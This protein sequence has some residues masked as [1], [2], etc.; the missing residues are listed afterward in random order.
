MVQ[1]LLQMRLPAWRTT[2]CHAAWHKNYAAL[3]NG[4]GDFEAR[5]LAL[6]AQALTGAKRN[7]LNTN[8]FANIH[9]WLFL[10]LRCLLLAVTGHD[11]HPNPDERQPPRSGPVLAEAQQRDKRASQTP[12]QN[13]ING[14]RG[15]HWVPTTPSAPLGTWTDGELG[16]PADGP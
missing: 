5:W 12:V 7:T 9:R 10:E 2:I 16:V 14:S 13:R 15:F 8:D 6:L 3:G 1:K 4:G 11:P